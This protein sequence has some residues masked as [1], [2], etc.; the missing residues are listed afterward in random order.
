M[1]TDQFTKAISMNNLRTH[2]K[3]DF[4]GY[5]F[6]LKI[7]VPVEEMSEVFTSGTW[8]LR[9]LHVEISI[10]IFCIRIQKICLAQ[11]PWTASLMQINESIVKWIATIQIQFKHWCLVPSLFQNGNYG[12]NIVFTSFISFRG[13]GVNHLIKELREII[14]KFKVYF[15]KSVAFWHFASDTAATYQK[16]LKN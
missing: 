11:K 12:G 15:R 7:Y 14:Q 3:S 13:K 16:F 5:Q 4:K 2:S 1:W 8:L 10:C 9:S 6:L